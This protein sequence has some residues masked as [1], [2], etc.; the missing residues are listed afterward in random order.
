[1]SGGPPAA[2]GVP[3]PTQ[4]GMREEKNKGCW[5][6]MTRCFSSKGEAGYGSKRSARDYEAEQQRL[7]QGRGATGSVNGLAKAEENKK[8][9]VDYQGRQRAGAETGKQPPAFLPASASEPQ[10]FLAPRSQQRVSLGHGEVSIHVD[11]LQVKIDFPPSAKDFRSP[12]LAPCQRACTRNSRQSTPPPPP[13]TTCR[14][15]GRATTREMHLLDHQI[16]RARF[17]R[18]DPV[19]RAFQRQEELPMISQMFNHSRR[20]V[21]SKR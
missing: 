12:P 13:E 16:S 9:G 3:P 4:Q 19:P 20:A 7:N 17:P 14:L 2:V 21:P 10:D 8:E 15:T 18:G 5:S 1:M 11:G 6:S